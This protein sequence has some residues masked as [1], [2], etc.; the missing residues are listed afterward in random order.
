V[1]TYANAANAWLAP[2]EAPAFAAA[3]QDA[4]SDPDRGK[5]IRNAR[6]TAEG[7]RRENVTAQ[8]LHLYADLHAFRTGRKAQPE[9]A[10]RFYSLR[11]PVGAGD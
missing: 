1:L 4:V 5:K 11:R 8:F 10:P 9:L 6:A 7:Y 2:A 3:I